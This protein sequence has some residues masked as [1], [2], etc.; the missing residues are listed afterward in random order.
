MRSRLFALLWIVWAGRAGALPISWITAPA[1]GTSEYSLFLVDANRLRDHTV[2]QAKA[3]LQSQLAPF[4][5]TATYVNN[6]LNDTPIHCG[7]MHFGSGQLYSYNRE[8]FLPSVENPPLSLTLDRGVKQTWAVNF[9]TPVVVTDPFDSGHT[10][11]VHFDQPMSQFGFWIQAS[12]AA[13]NELI[14]DVLRFVVDTDTDH[15]GVLE[16]LQI[17]K[18]MTLGLIEFVGIEVPSGFSDLN[19][20]PVG[21]V[22]QAFVADRFSSLPYAVPSAAGEPRG[23]SGLALALL[24]GNPAR[25]AVSMQLA[26]PTTGPAHAAVYGADGRLVRTLWG[27][28][29]GAGNHRLEWDGRTEGGGTA[30]AGVY[31]VQVTQQGRSATQRVVRVH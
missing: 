23:G 14:T 15:D 18:T 30:Q 9:R 8:S 20:V 28:P 21:G 5:R 12:S 19:V 17:E 25:G 26:L 29:S 22:T 3:H 7:P 13:G 10:V 16:Q 4:G 2:A 31:F 11:H 6:D 27:A 24:S 1:S